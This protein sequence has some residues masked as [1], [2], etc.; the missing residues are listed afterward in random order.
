M[1]KYD[2]PDSVTEY[3]SMFVDP[4][5]QAFKTAADIYTKRFDDN[6]QA[7]DL[8]YSTMAE[9]RFVP[10]EEDQTKEEIYNN[11]NSQLGSVVDQGS[12]HLADMAVNKA[13]RYY[14]SDPILTKKRQ[15]YQEHLKTK[16]KEQEVGI[17]NLYIPNLDEYQ[18]FK[19]VTQDEEGNEVINT[20]TDKAQAVEDYAGTALQ[21]IGNIAQDQ[22]FV[23][24]F[25]IAGEQL[26]ELFATG[27]I[28]G[29]S[30]AKVNNVIKAVLDAY[31]MTPAGAQLQDRL[32]NSNQNSYGR[33][34]ETQQ[35]TDAAMTKMLQ[36]YAKNQ[37]SYKE[38]YAINTDVVSPSSQPSYGGPNRA[39]DIF[40]SR[41]DPEPTGFS[42]KEQLEAFDVEPNST[43]DNS[44]SVN[45]EDGIIIDIA[46]DM[47]DEEVSNILQGTIFENVGNKDLALTIATSLSF[48]ADQKSVNIALAQLGLGPNDLPAAAEQANIVSQ[49]L[50]ETELGNMGTKILKDIPISNAIFKPSLGGEYKVI[51]NKQYPVG[52]WYIPADQ[53]DDDVD[54]GNFFDLGADLKTPTGRNVISQTQTIDGIE[55]AVIPN[56]FGKS[57]VYTAAASNARTTATA[58]DIPASDLFDMQNDLVVQFNQ[59]VKNEFMS[60][61]IKNTAANQLSIFNISNST[62]NSFKDIIGEMV[63]TNPRILQN[64]QGDELSMQFKQLIDKYKQ[65]GRSQYEAETAALQEFDRIVNK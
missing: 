61:G 53:I 13:V 29:V 11:I 40:N 44:Y 33:P 4:G 32:I 43:I 51:G 19:T 45:P 2:I 59:T 62:I 3:K 41:K 36:G 20:Y 7:A 23:A 57:H 34:L 63:K 58:Y 49:R 10:G 8:L 47:T 28:A 52:T 5:M 42:F 18:N 60:T 37:I 65:E 30:Q 48:S 26:K 56:A 38:D 22:R 9:E 25:G 1:G 6:K 54:L 50:A 39:I 27:Q 16:T 64:V 55:Y 17:N 15:N 21:L 46:K 14:T 31:K 24:G 35:A 12:Y